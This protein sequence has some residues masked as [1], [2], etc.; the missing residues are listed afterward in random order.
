MNVRM[1]KEEM[2]LLMP[3]SLSSAAWTDAHFASGTARGTDKP[4]LLQR[5][6]LAAKWLMELPR[7]RALLDELSTLSDHELAD[8]GLSRAELGM[9]FDPAFVAQRDAERSGA[10]H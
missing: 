5:I 10:I 4:T 3:A 2:A 1:P 8:I 9:V 7:R 6:G